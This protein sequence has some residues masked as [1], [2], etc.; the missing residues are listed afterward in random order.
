M[1]KI[2]AQLD[3]AN[4]IP[5][6]AR[7]TLKVDLHYTHGVTELA[8]LVEAAKDRGEGLITVAPSGVELL[9]PLINR[10]L[11]KADHSGLQNSLTFPVLPS[12][13]VGRLYRRIS[14]STILGILDV[15]RATLVEL[16]DRCLAQSKAEDRA[17]HD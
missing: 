7:E 3:P 17:E 16:V 10:D 2:T 9:V 4:M 11:R 15:V 5:E 14:I 12:Q 6:F 1:G 8:Q 13:I